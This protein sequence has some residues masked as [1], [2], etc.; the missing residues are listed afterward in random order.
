MDGFKQK[1]HCIIDPEK[2]HVTPQ[3]KDAP[4]IRVATGDIQIPE[5]DDWN[6]RDCDTTSVGDDHS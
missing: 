5:Q 2:W 6:S 1:L 4:E 3:P